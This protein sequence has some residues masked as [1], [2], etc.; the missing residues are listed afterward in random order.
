[1]IYTYLA[2]IISLVKLKRGCVLSHEGPRFGRKL[3]GRDSDSWEHI[4]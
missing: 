1:M 2:F 3:R 4:D